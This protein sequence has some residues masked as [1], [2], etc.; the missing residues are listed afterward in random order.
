[1]NIIR[2]N[3]DI[4]ISTAKGI[5]L[6]AAQSGTDSKNLMQ[7]IIIDYEKRANNKTSHN[8]KLLNPKTKRIGR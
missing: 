3:I 2:K 1:M 4:P 6:L 7:K 5:V 8:Y